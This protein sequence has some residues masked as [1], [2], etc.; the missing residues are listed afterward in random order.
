M[1]VHTYAKSLEDKKVVIM[2]CGHMQLVAHSTF[3]L[4]LYNNQ[5]N[6]FWWTYCFLKSKTTRNARNEYSTKLSKMW[7]LKEICL[8]IKENGLI[9]E[10]TFSQFL[11]F[12]SLSTLYLW[13]LRA[14]AAFKNPEALK[15][16]AR[17]E[18]QKRK[19][20]RLDDTM[21]Y[22]ATNPVYL[23]HK[24]MW[25]TNVSLFFEVECLGALLHY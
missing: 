25:N 18:E 7:D 24:F 8:K 16:K 20:L 19:Y 4:F 12:L 17:K 21:N 13:W 5:N 11:P 22:H 2:A 3:T 23:Q 9:P 10:D 14:P 1:L 6:C 15:W